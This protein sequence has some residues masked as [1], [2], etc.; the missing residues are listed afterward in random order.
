MVYNDIVECMKDGGFRMDRDSDIVKRYYDTHAEAEWER[1]SGHSFEFSVT[2]AMMERHVKP[3][4]KILDLGGGPGRYAIHCARRGCDVTL[5]VLSEAN[6][7]VALREAAKAGVAIRAF[8]KNAVDPALLELGEGSYDHV[9]VMG[10]LYHL[11]SEVDR[12]TVVRHAIALLKP[13]GL[14]HVSFLLLFAGMIYYMK[15][16]P[17]GILTDPQREPYLTDVTEGIPY[18]GEAFTQAFFIPPG[19]ILPFMS[20][21]ALEP[22]SLFGQE[23]ILAPQEKNL[24]AASDAARAEWL[25][26]ALAV[27]ER[28]EYLSYAEHAIYVGRRPVTDHRASPGAEGVPR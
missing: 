5:V 9:F 12:E 20:R 7:G 6:V 23:S 10:P 24:L 17:E 14:V 13:G 19:D 22:V 4:Q 11:L 3:G 18:A 28:P 2:I 1:L 15:N 8:A 26:V 21:F 16:D 27:A 25:R